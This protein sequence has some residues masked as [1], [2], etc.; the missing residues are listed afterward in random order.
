[1]RLGGQSS[2]GATQCVEHCLSVTQVL[3]VEPEKKEK[4]KKTL[5]LKKNKTLTVKGSG[6]KSVMKQLG[7]VKAI[8]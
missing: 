5:P 1:M 6:Q 4:K 2:S 3:C 8:F 7:E